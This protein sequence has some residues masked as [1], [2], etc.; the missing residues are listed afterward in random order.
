MDQVVDLNGQV[1]W[2]YVNPHFFFESSRAGLNNWVF[3]AFR[4]S[5]AEIER[6]R[7]P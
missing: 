2:E 7:H 5:T 1:V 4:Y 6:A 3:R